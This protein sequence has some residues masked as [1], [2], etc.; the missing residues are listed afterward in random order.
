MHS[1]LR[2]CAQDCP[3]DPGPNHVHCGEVQ[4]LFWRAICG[5]AMHLGLWQ[6]G[7]VARSLLGNLS[8]TLPVSDGCH[9]TA[10]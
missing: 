2:A 1:R 4:S 3:G 5:H 6:D 8:D 7:T 9:I 10:Q